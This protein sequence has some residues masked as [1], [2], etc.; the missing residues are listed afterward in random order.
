M[1]DLRLPLYS[2]KPSFLNLFMKKLTRERVDTDHF[3]E[4]L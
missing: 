1:I 2:M 4:R 3:R